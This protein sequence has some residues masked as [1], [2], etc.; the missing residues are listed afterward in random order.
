MNRIAKIFF[1]GIYFLGITLAAKAEPTSKDKYPL[2]QTS[3]NPDS[4]NEKWNSS[5]I[6]RTG[7]HLTLTAGYFVSHW[8]YKDGETIKQNYFI[9]MINYTYHLKMISPLSIFL[10][11]NFGYALDLSSQDKN[12]KSSAGKLILPGFLVG[13][14]LSFSTHIK[15]NLGFNMGWAR[16]IAL[17]YKE[18]VYHFTTRISPEV[19]FSL[20]YFF[21]A[22]WA[23]TTSLNYRRETFLIDNEDIKNNLKIFYG[24]TR[25]ALGLNFGL[26]FHKL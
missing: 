26:T 3:G 11:S 12:I 7:H 6:H 13:L 17:Y 25:D 16:Y 9:K 2:T 18:D 4:A 20:D 5:F 8:N 15:A 22:N 19:Y 24:A 14:S 1:L 21:S 10:G 23:I